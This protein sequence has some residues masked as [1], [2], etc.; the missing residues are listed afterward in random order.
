MKANRLI[1]LLLLLPAVSTFA[2]DDAE[3]WYK[4]EG[5]YTLINNANSNIQKLFNEVEILKTNQ[6]LHKIGEEYNGGII[7]WVDESK[8][9]GLVVSK[10]DV[11]K[12]GIQWRNGASGNRIT[13]ARGDGI[14]SGETNTRLIIASQT[15]DDQKGRFAALA[16]SQFKV[17]AD[18][19]TPCTIPIS[20]EALCYGG[21]Y[22]PS[23]FELQL[24]RMNLPQDHRTSFA[25]DFYWTSTETSASNAWLINFASG[26]V[27]SSNKSNTTGRVRAI[28]RF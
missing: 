27:S 21:W 4:I 26:E 11:T 25:P 23:A 8:Q 5:A 24:M 17:Q 15:I 18:G 10:I 7:F 28:S 14:G 12:E 2:A 13:N 1:G 3:V 16:A 20:I 19:E 9:H 22:L 6:K